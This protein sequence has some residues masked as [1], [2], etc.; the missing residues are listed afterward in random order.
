MTSP[1]R[2]EPRLEPVA[3][4]P[5]GIT[6]LS[7]EL[8]RAHW[9]LSNGR[10]WRVALSQN[11]K[12]VPPEILVASTGVIFVG[13]YHGTVAALSPDD[14]QFIARVALPSGNAVFWREFS[15]FVVA[16]G[17]MAV[18]VFRPSGEFL[19]QGATP[20]VIESIELKGEV[21]RLVDA[22]GYVSEFEIA[23]GKSTK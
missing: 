8:P 3:A 5:G 7:D 13:L 19:W 2:E 21:L 6:S 1:S 15:R 17:E 14:G 23:T 16:S 11:N 20:D 4:V 10:G 18:G 12:E 22:A 9:I